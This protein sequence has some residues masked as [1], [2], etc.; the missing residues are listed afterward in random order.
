MAP[1]ARIVS[2]KRLVLVPLVILAIANLVMLALVIGPLASRVETLEARATT[3]ALAVTAAERD[4]QTARA[5]ATGK[6]QAVTDLA[7]FYREV[8][9]PDHPQARRL[10]YLRLAQLARTANLDFDRRTFAE[11]QPR[12]ARL[13]RVD[14]TMT[15]AGTYRD[16][17]RFLHA[18]E[19][20]EDFVVIRGIA[21]ARRDEG[22]GLLDASLDLSTYYGPAD[23]N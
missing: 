5:L 17:R 3:S 14:M 21:V 19:T 18:V 10:T 1:F 15:V 8:L 23:G 20:G 4:V 13:T 6:S 9:P 16:L 2:D 7:V 11:D 12:D 22:Q